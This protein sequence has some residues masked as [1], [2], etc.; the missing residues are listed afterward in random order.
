MFG[1]V[2]EQSHMIFGQPDTLFILRELKQVVV[3]GEPLFGDNGNFT[4]GQHK[5]LG[6]C[7]NMIA[8]LAKGDLVLAEAGSGTYVKPII[9]LLDGQVEFGAAEEKALIG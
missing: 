1:N 9:L 4:V 3:S 2:V 5:F 8:Q 7:E 6:A